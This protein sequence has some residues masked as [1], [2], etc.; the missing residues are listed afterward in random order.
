MNIYLRSYRKSGYAY[1]NLYQ[2]KR[3]LSGF[4]KFEINEIYD[5]LKSLRKNRVE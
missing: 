4:N 3:A 1:S 5:V 2:Q